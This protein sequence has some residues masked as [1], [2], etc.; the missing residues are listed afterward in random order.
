MNHDTGN[1][2]FDADCVHSAV[3]S[4]P[5]FPNI[6]IFLFRYTSTEHIIIHKSFLLPPQRPST[7]NN[8]TKPKTAIHD[9]PARIC[10]PRGFLRTRRELA[11]KLRS[12]ER[13][14]SIQRSASKSKDTK[15]SSTKLWKERSTSVP[16]SSIWLHVLSSSLTSR[17][18]SIFASTQLHGIF[19]VNTRIGQRDALPTID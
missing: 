4:S 7:L 11:C 8:A 6:L 16:K 12:R 18:Y 1:H 10:F 2:M 3:G 15:K 9:P 5:K 17:N 14:R 13:N 19:T